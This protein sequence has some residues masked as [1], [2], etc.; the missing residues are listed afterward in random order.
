[1][2]KSIYCIGA[3]I[4]ER[5]REKGWTQKEL[6][7]RVGT[8]NKYIS[9]V[10]NGVKFPSLEMLICLSREMDVSLDYLISAEPFQEDGD[11]PD[12]VLPDLP[13]CTPEEK[14]FLSDVVHSIRTD[15]RKYRFHPGGREK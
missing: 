14:A 4:R 8:S 3:R 6:A 10:E 5:R 13:D 9:H 2:R 7:L 11:R 12:G 1:M 15:L